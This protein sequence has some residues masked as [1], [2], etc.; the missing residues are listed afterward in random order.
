ME[1]LSKKKFANLKIETSYVLPI[2][3]RHIRL[4]LTKQLAAGRAELL[5]RNED[6]D[7]YVEKAND[8]MLL[9]SII[10]KIAREQV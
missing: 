5:K 6:S 4:W 8:L 1:K 2:E 10:A 9:D 3:L 7:E